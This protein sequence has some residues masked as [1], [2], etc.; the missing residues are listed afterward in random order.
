MEFHSSS[1]VYMHDIGQKKSPNRY[2]NPRICGGAQR[3]AIFTVLDERM[4]VTDHSVC[5]IS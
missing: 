4:P 1:I 3:L 5:G 2:P